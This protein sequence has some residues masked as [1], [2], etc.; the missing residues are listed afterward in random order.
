MSAMD[1]NE[2]RRILG[3]WASGVSVVATTNAEAKPCG[4]TATAIASVSLEPLLVLACIERDA[5]THDCIGAAGY[6]SINILESSQE[7]IARR[8]AASQVDDK[9]QGIAFHTEATGAPIFDEALAWIDC[10]VWAEH[11]AGD[12][13]IFIGEV[14]AGNARD[15]SPLFYNRGAYGRLTS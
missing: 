5:D 9:F 14:M 11:E 7:R 10:R 13:T 12:H 3:H 2:F 15:G 1:S 8:F 6:F 4:L